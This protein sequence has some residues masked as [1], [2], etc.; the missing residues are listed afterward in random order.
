ME[1]TRAGIV[2]LTL[3]FGCVR[4]GYDAPLKA[5]DAGETSNMDASLIDAGKRFDASQLDASDQ[6]AIDAATMDASTPRDAGPASDAST[7]DD[8]SSARDASTTD[9]AGAARDAAAS[10]DASASS[11][12]AQADA[13]ST[14]AA[15]SSNGPC[16]FTS[17]GNRYEGKKH[18]HGF[19][20]LRN[21]G[22][23]TWTLPIISFD[24]PSTANI[25]N[26]ED[27]LP[28]AGWTL[29]SS[30]GHCEYTKTSPTL[31]IAPGASLSF[32]YSSNYPNNIADPA[33][34]NVNV[35]GCAAN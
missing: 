5:R 12:A 11:D 15:A 13:G 14:D 33:V 35:A 32:E 22:D 2:G 30:A 29:Q 3:M 16:S 18:F 28:G 6:P 21:T 1:F 4:I 7:T 8:A 27:V 34:A 20:T 17:T 24:L 9:D 25:C 19:L 23:S 10:G 26:D 31:S